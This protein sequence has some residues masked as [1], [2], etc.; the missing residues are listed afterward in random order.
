MVFGQSGSVPR[1]RRR[2]WRAVPVFVV[3]ALALTACSSGSHPAA[4]GGVAGGTPAAST[5]AAVQP[6]VSL[7]GSTTKVSYSKTLKINVKDGTFTS[8]RVASGSNELLGTVA[9][10]TWQS[11]TPPRPDSKYQAVATV[12]DSAGHTSTKTVS[13]KVAKVPDNQRLSF[14]VTPSGSGAVGIGQPVVVRWLTPVTNKKAIEKAMSVDATTPSG[15]SVVGSWSWLNSQ[16]VD[17]RPK[18]FWTPGTKVTLDMKIAGVKASSGRY[19][20]KDYTQSFKIGASHITQ[21]NASTHR[22]KVYRDGKL[23]DNWATGTGRAGLQTYSGTYIVL[24]KSSVVQMDSCS[25][26]ITCDKSGPDYYNEKEYW[27]TRITASGTFVHAASWDGELGRANTSHGCIHLADA[28]AK[29]FY[30]HA[31]IGDVVIVKNTGRGPQQRIATEDPG[32]Y[33]WNVSW[34]RWKAGSALS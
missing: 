27:A 26:G 12:K 5:P 31:V 16:E 23:V 13:F 17:W 20:R 18:A 10:S 30:N 33:D 22:L 29:N 32:L 1:G 14:T 21:V 3:G 9:G 7:T 8:M 15:A 34:S 6:T 11:E 28:N 4:S 25:A 19:G 2:P 24:G